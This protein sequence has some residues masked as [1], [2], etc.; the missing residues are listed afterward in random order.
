MPISI[1]MQSTQQTCNKC[2]TQ[3]PIIDILS[4]LACLMPLSTI[5]QLFR[6][7][8]VLLEKETRVPGENHRPG[9]SH[10]QTLSHNVVSSTHHH[11]QGLIGTDQTGSCKSN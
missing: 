3:I 10:W 6:G 4:G 5:F 1:A 8:S 7:W 2:K 11:E 9:T